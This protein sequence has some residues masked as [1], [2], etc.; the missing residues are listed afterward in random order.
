MTD[1]IP[2]LAPDGVRGFLLAEVADQLA[3]LGMSPEEVPDD[4]DLL[5]QGALDSLGL[6]ELIAAVEDRYGV[7][8]DFE[9]LDPE[10]LGVVGPFCRYIEERVRAATDAR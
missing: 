5:A 1:R 6:V 10:S 8:L 3:A 9:D 7:E 2:G 4:F